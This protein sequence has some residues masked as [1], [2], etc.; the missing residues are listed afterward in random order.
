[1]KGGLSGHLFLLDASGA[2]IMPRGW[3]QECPLQ[4]FLEG[5]GVSNLFRQM[6]VRYIDVSVSYLWRG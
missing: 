6:R 4:T 1:M 3:A 5:E 2:A